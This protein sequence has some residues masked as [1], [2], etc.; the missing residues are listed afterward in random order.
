MRRDR[1]AHSGTTNIVHASVN[2]EGTLLAFTTLTRYERVPPPLTTATTSAPAAGG[3]E[4]D[5][6]YDDMCVIGP[7]HGSSSPSPICPLLLPPTLPAWPLWLRER[8]AGGRLSPSL[9][10]CPSLTRSPCARAHGYTVVVTHALSLSTAR[11]L[12]L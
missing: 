7:C 9:H 2:R 4:Q 8:H 12:G 1:Y 5:P 3:Q 6:L 10:P 11:A